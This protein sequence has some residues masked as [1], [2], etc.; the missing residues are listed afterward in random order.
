MQGKTKARY[1]EVGGEG[2]IDAWRGEAAKISLW[3]TETRRCDVSEMRE[4]SKEGG[5][6]NLENSQNRVV[7]GCRYFVERKGTY[8]TT[9]EAV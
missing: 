5:G 1:V 8:F 6:G 2:E 7:R 3:A 9:T 4:K